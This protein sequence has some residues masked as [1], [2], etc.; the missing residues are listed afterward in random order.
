MMEH[1]LTDSELL[2]WLDEMLPVERMTAIEKLLRRSESLRRR[3]AELRVRRDHGAHSV[4]EIWRRERLSCPTL[5][6]LGSYLLGTLAG[7]H[8]GYVAFHLD[9]IGCRFCAA[10]LHDMQQS[11]RPGREAPDRRRKYFESSAG[12][13][14]GREEE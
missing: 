2:A 10:N 5:S 9:A 6:Q 8:A 12:L 13:L 1:D 14:R 11:Q 3:T 7:E 4:G